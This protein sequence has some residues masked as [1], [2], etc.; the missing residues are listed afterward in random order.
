MDPKAVTFK[1]YKEDVKH[2][3]AKA[4]AKM[5]EILHDNKK[6]LRK[7]ELYDDYNEVVGYHYNGIIISSSY[8][9]FLTKYKIKGPEKDKSVFMFMKSLP[10]NETDFW[11]KYCLKRQCECNVHM[12]KF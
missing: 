5:D 12:A 11:R 10:D 4:K 8:K 1:F 3:Y 9:T 2:D 7:V 6:I